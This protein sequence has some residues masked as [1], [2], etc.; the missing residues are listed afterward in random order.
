[1]QG[2]E[3][4]HIKLAKYVQNTCNVRKN[5]RWWVVF[6]HEFVSIVCVRELDPLNIT[7]RSKKKT[8]KTVNSYI[9]NRVTK[10]PAIYCFC[11][12]TKASESDDKCVIC[13]SDIMRLIQQSV[14]DSKV[15]SS[16]KDILHEA[17]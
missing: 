17:V 10:N 14:T 15:H 2:R 1:M 7:C 9:P 8:G 13:S 16:L 5:D 3:A 12:N 6:K 11:G 4:K